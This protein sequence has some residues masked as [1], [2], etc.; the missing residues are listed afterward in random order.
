MNK[1]SHHGRTLPVIGALWLIWSYNWIVVKEGLQ[2][3]G[4]FDFSALRCIFG[5]AVM[6][7]VLK[8]SGRSLAPP[9]LG[10]CF[11]LGL[12]QT[13]GFLCFSSW[14]LVEGAVGKSAVLIYTFPFWTLLF[15]RIALGERICGLQ[16]LGVALAG[17]GLAL[18]LEPWNAGGNQFSRILAVLSGV[19]WAISTI[20]AK[21]WRSRDDFDLLRVTTWQLLLGGIVCSAIAIAVPARPVVWNSYFFTLI[22]ASG[23]VAT[24]FGWMLWLHILKRLTA[25]V[26]GLGMMAVPALGVLFSRLHYGETFDRFEITGMLMLGVSLLVLSWFNLRNQ[27]GKPALPQE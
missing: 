9:P 4:P 7:A 12:F 1:T 6:F 11:L 16:W 23:I 27:Q 22:A 15:A 14:A 3:S 17:T 26:A 13:T 25:G 2:F 24:A 18:L 10:R 20:I 5:S 8:F 21:H 19:S